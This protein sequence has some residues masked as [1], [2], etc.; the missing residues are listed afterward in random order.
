MRPAGSPCLLRVVIALLY[1]LIT[2]AVMGV[3]LLLIYRAACFF[4]LQVD[5]WALILCAVMAVG[6]NFA[7]I[8]LSN[9]LT[10]DHLMVIIVLVLLSAALMTLFNEYLLR[11]HAPVLAGA[12]GAFSEDEMFEADEAEASDALVAA[13][14]AE[15][16]CLPPRGKG[17]ARSIG[18]K[19][20]RRRKRK[21]LAGGAVTEVVVTRCAEAE[22]GAAQEM[23]AS[24][25]EGVSPEGETSPREVSSAA[26]GAALLAPDGAEAH[27]AAGAAPPAS[28]DAAMRAEHETAS[29]AA[30]GTADVDDSPRAQPMEAQGVR[31][32]SSQG[33][34]AILPDALLPTR[35]A[36]KSR[37][38]K[39]PYGGKRRSAAKGQTGGR[40]LGRGHSSPPRWTPP[41]ASLSTGRKRRGASK[42][43]PPIGL[44]L[45]RLRT[46]DEYLD[47]AGKKRAAGCV[48]DAILTYQQ[49]LGKFREDSYLPFLVIELG[50]MYKELG[51][52]A[53]ALS[54]YRSALR[55]SAVKLQ[56]GMA[57]AF[58]ENIAYLDT[59][60]SVLSRRRMSNTPFSQIPPDCRSEIERRFTARWAEKNTNV[61]EEHLNDQKKRGN[62]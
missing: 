18:K 39:G 54:A 50:N 42:K 28:H 58:R 2:F 15:G 19:K 56:A 32:A 31:E 22:E 5:R 36:G 10:L 13:T 61:Q 33:T 26:P 20:A 30:Q 1:F 62:P 27:V 14:V 45:A 43:A 3:S 35:I 52:Y 40:A 17:A 51:D 7:S 48:Y 41:T 16:R 60:V 47:Y 53:E 59:I 9:I 25:G 46:L 57:D 8:Y 34:V 6:V 29:N 4:G 23:G 11:R 44:V 37:S 24:H 38:P 49:A 12:D 21:T 55:L